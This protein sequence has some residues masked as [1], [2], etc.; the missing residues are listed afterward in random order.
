MNGRINFVPM[1]YNGIRAVNDLIKVM[2]SEEEGK[3][4]KVKQ[5]GKD[6]STIVVEQSVKIVKVHV[7]FT[8]DDG[9]V[10]RHEIDA[11]KIKGFNNKSFLNDMVYDRM[12]H[13]HTIQ[14]GDWRLT[15][16]DRNGEVSFSKW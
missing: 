7:N 10:L 14:S 1:Q 12:D 5:Y 16:R 13:I 8:R 11:K 2:V 6:G 15:V 4:E 9:E 3:P